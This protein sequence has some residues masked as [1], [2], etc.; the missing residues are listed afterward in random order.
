M[1]F[2]SETGDRAFTDAIQ[3]IETASGVEVVVA[4]RANARP[5]FVQHA[6]AG[7]I[8]AAAVL[9]YAVVFEWDVWAILAFPVVSGVLAALIVERNVHATK[10][11]TGM[12]VFLAIRPRACEIVGDVAVIEHVGQAALDDA[13]AKLA[14][15]I[16]LGAEATAKT[17]ASFATMLAAAIPRAPGDIDELPDAPIVA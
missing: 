7:L 12:L 8:A 1:R 16:P 15:A 4:V 13:S 3:T 9:V 10:R 6:I 17:L 2:T 11:R 5:W 14:A